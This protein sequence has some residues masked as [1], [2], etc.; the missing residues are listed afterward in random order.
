VSALFKIMHWPGSAAL[1][2]LA[3]ATAVFV[4]MPILV[5]AKNESDKANSIEVHR[6]VLIVIGT[7]LFFLIQ[8]RPH[9][10]EYLD[11]HPE[12]KISQSAMLNP[13]HK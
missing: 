1:L 3:V 10:K 6:F 5:F 4:Y 11:A 8:T 9:S 12:L 7:A 2:V 13:Q